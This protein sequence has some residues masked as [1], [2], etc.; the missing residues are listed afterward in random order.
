MVCGSL[1]SYV[2]AMQQLAIG[3]YHELGGEGHPL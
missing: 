2:P 1:Q 3:G